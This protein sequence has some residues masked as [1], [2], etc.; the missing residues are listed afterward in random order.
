MV[1]DS[2]KYDV[3]VTGA[4]GYKG[5]VLIPKL[6]SSGFRVVA[7]DANWFG[8]HLSDH[9]NLTV[10]ECD[11]RNTLALPDFEFVNIIHLASVAND[12]TSDL[13]PY[14]TWEISVLAT[15]QL[16]EFYLPR[17][18]KNFVYAS[19]GS[20]YGVQPDADIVESTALV[21]LS[22]YNKTKMIAER[23]LMSYRDDVNVSIIRPATVCGLSPRMRFDVAVNILSIQALEN[24]EITVL[25]GDQM[26]PNVHIDD[27]ADLYV[28]ILQSP[29][30][31]KGVF[32][33]GF[34]NL[35]IIEIAELVASRTGA[36][37]LIKESNDARTYRM[38]SDKILSKGFVPK[39][40]V[41]DAIN[42]I[43]TAFEKGLISNKPHFNN[44]T[45]MKGRMNEI[46]RSGQ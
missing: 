43:C 36:N 26:R 10:I 13:N 29:L 6:L 18:L 20:V 12:P 19:S 28:K 14:L 2:K 45:W 16:V 21:P 23:V 42:E 11:I 38:N 1:V 24:K 35:K 39:K 46:E 8:N 9:P 5:S 30:D 3:L 44:L 40:T 37:I 33:C 27:I 41:S 7:L 25:G 34:E 17:G 4:M 22:E 15:Q 31:Y 32:N